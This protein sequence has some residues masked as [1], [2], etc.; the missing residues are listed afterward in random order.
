LDSFTWYENSSFINNSSFLFY[1][2]YHQC[3]NDEYP[4]G[5]KCIKI[6]QEKQTW[7]FAQ[8]KCLSIGSRLIQLNDILQEKKL[9]HFLL[10]NYEQ[11]QTSFWISDEKA[12]YNGKKNIILSI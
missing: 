9:T 5:P 12:K 8:E 7:N 11:Q 2:G 6:F 1:L 10:T 3:T 4:L